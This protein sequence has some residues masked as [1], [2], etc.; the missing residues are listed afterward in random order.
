MG[1]EALKQAAVAKGAKAVADI[2]IGS[3]PGLES[4]VYEFG[5]DRKL[6][7]VSP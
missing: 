1:E 2:T 4:R 6:F 3:S 7:K 5:K